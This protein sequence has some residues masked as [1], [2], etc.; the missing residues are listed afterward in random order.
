MQLSQ[1]TKDFIE[2]RVSRFPRYFDRIDRVKVTTITESDTIEVEIVVHPP[3]GTIIAKDRGDDLH[4]VVDRA[5]DKIERSLKR[6]KDKLSERR[7]RR[8]EAIPAVEG[9]EE[10]EESYEDILLALLEE[11]EK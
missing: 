3:G 6:L 11:D 1:E 4:V 9:A 2:D 8:E 10:E 5:A 7:A